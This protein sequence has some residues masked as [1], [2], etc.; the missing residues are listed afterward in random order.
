M[1]LISGSG[2]GAALAADHLD[3]T[4]L[5]LATLAP[6]TKDKIKAV[7]PESGDVTNPIDA[8]GA[9]FYDPGIMGRLIDAVA[10][11]P[12]KPIIA[13]A[14]NASPAPHDRMRRIAAAIAD[15]ARL[16]GCSIVTYQ[17]SPLGPLDGE[18]V[19]SLHAA[20]VPLLMGIGSAMGALRH[21]AQPKQRS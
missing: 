14:V 16:S 7:L 19:A 12:A 17:V 20:G 13:V 8:T 4:G 3:G 5:T 9:V 18:L 1:V 6:A 11:D 2:G 10:C 21:L 15:T